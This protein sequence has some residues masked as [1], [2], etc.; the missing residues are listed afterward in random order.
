ML[1]QFATDVSRTGVTPDMSLLFRNLARGESVQVLLLP[2]WHAD[3]NKAP[4]HRSSWCK[5]FE[6]RQF[7][8]RNG[9]R[10]N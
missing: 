4:W 7:I 8:A 9:P 5:P 2:T 6:R 10:T 1:F 3:D